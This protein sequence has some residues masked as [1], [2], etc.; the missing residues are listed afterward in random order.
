MG[1]YYSSDISGK[2]W[3]A[4]QSSDDAGFFGGSEVKPNYLEYSFDE[5]DLPKIKEGVKKCKKELGKYKKK[6]DKFFDEN[7][8]YNDKILREETGTTPEKTTNLL[9]WYARLRLG[10]K[11]LAKVKETGQCCFDAKL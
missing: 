7:E 11:I 3:F 1:R 2:F 4:V 8:T 5:D 9:R 6:L 10:E